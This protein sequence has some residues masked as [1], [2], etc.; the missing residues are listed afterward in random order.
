MTVY[1]EPLGAAT[2]PRLDAATRDP[3]AVAS[4]NRPRGPFSALRGWVI[5]L[6]RTLVA[7]S[8]GGRPLPRAIGAS[9]AELARLNGAAWTIEDARHETLRRQGALRR[10]M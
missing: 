1:P 10:P 8:V 2:R 5:A 3:A 4:Q 9:D 7:R 6:T